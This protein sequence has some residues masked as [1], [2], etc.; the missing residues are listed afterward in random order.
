VFRRGPPVPGLLYAAPAAGALVGSLTSGWLGGIR[1]QGR[2]VIVAVAAWGATI[3]AFGYVRVLWAALA[4]LVVA[5]WVDLVSAVLRS[6]IVQSA[7]AEP[8]RSRIFTA[9]GRR[10]RR[11][12]TW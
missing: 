8:F 9:D 11:S 5:G 7:V 4:L 2:A 6:T 12:A 3:V 10:R 1:R